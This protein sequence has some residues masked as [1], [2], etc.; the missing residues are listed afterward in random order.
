MRKH[1]LAGRFRAE[2]VYKDLMVRTDRFC[3]IYYK[4]SDQSQIVLRIRTKTDDHELLTKA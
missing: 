3:A 1:N 4:P 2:I